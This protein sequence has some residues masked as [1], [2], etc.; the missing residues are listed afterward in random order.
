M[1]AFLIVWNITG[2]KVKLDV[3]FLS[4]SVRTFQNIDFWQ[5]N[6][7]FLFLYLKNYQKNNSLKFYL[8]LKSRDIFKIHKLNDW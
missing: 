2:V 7:T 4:L 1:F 5:N 6:K 3:I 8:F